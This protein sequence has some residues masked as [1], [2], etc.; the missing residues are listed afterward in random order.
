MNA[1]I[2]CADSGY[3]GRVFTVSHVEKDI[4]SLRLKRAVPLTAMFINVN[5]PLF[6]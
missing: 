1:S 3:V 4:M 2:C 6:H 5:I